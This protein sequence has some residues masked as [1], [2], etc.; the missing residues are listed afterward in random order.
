[1]LR[2]FIHEL[3]PNDAGTDDG[4]TTSFQLL[5]IH[6]YMPNVKDKYMMKAQEFDNLIIKAWDQSHGISGPNA[7]LV[8]KDKMKHLKS[9]IKLWARQFNTLKSEEKVQLYSKLA[10]VERDLEA[11]LGS[12]SLHSRHIM[13]YIREFFETGKLPSGCNS[14]FITLIPKV[15]NPL[16]VSDFRPISLIGA[17]YKIL[18]KIL[19]NRLSRVID[20]ALHVAVEDA[21]DVGLYHRVQGEF[22]LGCTDE[23][24]KIPWISWNSVLASKLKGRLGIGSLEA[25]NLSLLKKWRCRIFNSPQALW[26]KFISEIHGSYDTVRYVFFHQC[27]GSGTWFRIVGA[28]NDM[29]D[30]GIIPHSSIKLQVKDGSATRFWRDTWLGDIPLERQ[31]PRLFCLEAN[32]DC[33]VR[34]RWQNGWV[35]C[36][37]RN[38][39]GGVTASQLDSLISMLMNVKITEGQDAWQWNLIGSNIFTIKDIRIYIDSIS[40]S[41]FPSGQGGVVSFLEKLIFLVWR[42]LR[43]RIPT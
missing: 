13:A 22:L 15:D 3:N 42:I 32:K 33:L 38:F 40:L 36:W 8:F 35:R 5:H 12:S 31:F 17:Q 18:A 23:I 10:E 41:E 26:V 37:T 29:H 28:I 7:M 2:R 16:V 43:D 6:S 30:K 27:G 21:I 11:G 4:I 19:A 9:N 14:L 39:H 1:M 25:L 24:K 20:S 34:D